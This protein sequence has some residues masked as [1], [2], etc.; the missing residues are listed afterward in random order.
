MTGASLSIPASPQVRTRRAFSI[1][2]VVITASI[3]GVVGAIA[4][5]RMVSASENSKAEGLHAS[6]AALQRALDLYVEEHGGL[7][8]NQNPDGNPTNVPL[9][10]IRRLTRPTD[11]A[12]NIDPQG[13]F[14]PYLRELPANLFT[15]NQS[16][17]FDG[18]TTPQN[19]AWRFDT[20][21]NTITPDQAK[22]VEVVR[23]GTKVK[24]GGGTLT[25]IDVGGGGGGGTLPDDLPQLPDL[26]DLQI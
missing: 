3:A 24:A 1:I 8:A 14:G 6:A 12:G 20:N 4:V 25:I 22:S 5:P 11:A 26:G 16:V 9:T 10:F 17:R 7:N 18:A 2:E 21:T 15:T 19:F 13:M 23:G